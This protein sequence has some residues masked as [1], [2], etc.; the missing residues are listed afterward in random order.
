[1]PRSD[2]A[3]L[4]DRVC[5]PSLRA[6]QNPDGGWGFREGSQS[7]V[8][9]TAWAL[10]ALRGVESSGELQQAGFRF[11]R[12]SQLADGSWP[13]SPGQQT[14]CWVTFLGSWAL[15]VDS[16]SQKAIGSALEWI[17]AD[18]PREVNV[19][20][21]MIR[22]F[23]TG[24]RIVSQD[25]SLRGWGWTPHTASWVEPTALA[26]IALEQ[27]PSH[28][29][30][31][32]AAKRREIAT[33]LLYDRMCPG[34]GW[35]C[36]NPMVYGVAGEALVEPTVWALVALRG[37]PDRAE[38]VESLA[39]LR[40]SLSGVLGAGSLALAR[41]CLRLYGEDWPKTTPSVAE[42]YEANATFGDVMAIAWMCMALG[43][44]TNWLKTSTGLA[45]THAYS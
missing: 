42:M 26:L 45:R 23:T 30:P 14:G 15:S 9:P 7:R 32:T 22:R 10:L 13:A 35:N 3:D 5:L 17:C 41:V 1:M 40:R 34:G 8:E 18:W 19:V 38:N 24:G 33:A 43:Q 44:R 31:H 2:D 27:A 4:L 21:R 36:G 6:A 12:A 37:Q 39:C 20:I 11:L 16:E 28:L 29:L 25:E